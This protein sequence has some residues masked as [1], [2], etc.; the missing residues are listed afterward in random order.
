MGDLVDRV[1]ELGQTAVAVTDHGEVSGHLRFQKA[2]NGWRKQPGGQET[3]TDRQ[4]RPIYGI[5]TYMAE[6][7]FVRDGK[8]GENYDHMVLLAKDDQG[9]R[10]LWA[11]SSR[12]YIEG[13]YYANAR[14]DWELLQEYHEGLVATGACLSGVVPKY[15]NDEHPQYNPDKAA[16]RLAR[17]LEIFGED[18]YLEIHT[19]RD[20]TQV[21][22]NHALVKL[23]SDMG[24]P[25][26]AVSDAHYL[27]PDDWEDHELLTAMQMSLS[28]DD[29][30]RYQ[31]G[32]NQLCMFGESEVRERLA[33][34]GPDVV[35][36]AV[37]NTAKI[38]A[39]CDAALPGTR[40]MPVFFDTPE[41]DL[42]RTRRMAEEGFDRK[43]RQH[44]AEDKWPEY[45]QRLEYEFGII[46]SKGFPG[47]FLTVADIVKWAKAEGML[48]GP[49]RGSA[50]GS[51]LS[52]VLDIT[53]IDPIKAGL[54][55]ER[56]L[57]PGRD[58]LPDIDMDFPQLERP[59]VRKH[60]EEQYGL[61]N[62]ATIG[63][64][65]KLAPK[66]LMRDLGRGLR[67]PLQEIN[68][69]NKIVD[70]FPDL[71]VAH[72]ETPW[73]AIEAELGDQLR[74]YLDK[75]PRLFTLMGK[76]GD[77]I[78]HAGAHAA[79]VV[80]SKDSLLGRLPLRFKSDDI[81]TQVDFNDVEEL[82]F[83]KIDVLGLR[84]LSTLM[85]AYKLVQQFHPDAD[86]PF[87]HDWQYDWDKFYEDPEVH[88]SLWAGKNIGVFQLESA[89]LRQ[90]AKRFQ[91]KSL[92]DICAMISVYRPGITRTY[93]EETGLNL[94]EL[95][96]QKRGGERQATYKHELLRPILEPTHGNFLYQEQ[97]MQVCHVLAGYS[98]AETD[99]VRKILGKKLVE[100]MK[101]ERQIFV[102]GCKL[103]D[104]AETVAN[105]I[106]D[107]MVAFGLYG[108]NRCL[109][110]KSLVYRPN[111]NGSQ[112]AAATIESLY[113][114][115]HFEQFLLPPSREH[116]PGPCVVC[117]Q[118]ATRCIPG[119]KRSGLLYLR[120][121]CANCISWHQV[122]KR[123]GL[124]L[125]AEKDG[126]IVPDRLKDV[127]FQG[128]QPV[129]RIT[130]ANGMF[131]EATAN[132]RSL[133][134]DG[135]RRTDEL[136]PGDEMIVH[137]E[138][139]PT[140]W[141]QPRYRVN[142]PGRSGG[143][144][145][146]QRWTATAVLDKRCS[147]CGT[148]K[149]RIERSHTDGHR[150][151]NAPEN[152]AW[153][154]RGCHQKR[155]RLHHGRRRFWEKGHTTAASVVVSVDYVGVFPTY[156]IEMAGENHNFV[157]NG[158]VTH[159][160]HGYA[161]AMIAY[162]CAWMKHFFPR[163]FMTALFQTNEEDSPLYA[164]ECQR[165]GIP[166]RGPDINES[167]EDFTLTPGGV[168]R[169]GLAKIKYVASGSKYL[170][171]FRP[172]TGVAD[173]TKRMPKD[174]FNKRAATS[175][176]IVGA[177]DSLVQP[178]DED[179]FPGWPKAQIALRLYLENRKDKVAREL[180]NVCRE[181]ECAA[182]AE[183]SN[184]DHLCAGLHVADRGFCEKEYL[185]SHISHDPLAPYMQLLSSEESFPGEDNMLPGEVCRLGGII[186]RV[187][188]LVTKKGKNPGSEMCQFWVDLPVVVADESPDGS[189][190]DE[191]VQ[192]V[193]FPEA[194]QK[195][196]AII[197]PGAPVL[198][199]VRRMDEGLSLVRLFRLDQL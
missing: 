4:C 9:L 196:K 117:G 57:D 141:R 40:S 169:Y 26:I 30:K 110:G 20:P 76:F 198:C 59:L 119:K 151:N 43:I 71:E 114:R 123:R 179:R 187:R 194:W 165:L 170:A 70:T 10:N 140:D 105:S 75:Y 120:G 52:Y 186:N 11:L 39:Q 87:Y 51:L 21:K 184:F 95:Y 29:P 90:L 149:G 135:Y 162:W 53:E 100:K 193:T 86:I 13:S 35:E 22:V 157:A 67:V 79:G 61:L 96:L 133:T 107:D 54:I 32:P 63:T 131:L 134:A 132:H 177:L 48:A 15:L 64:L 7:R 142:A 74:P 183:H 174:K 66:T 80:L 55:F 17:L 115:I 104:I 89:G 45:E 154:C 192:I 47:Y 93:D 28:Y 153:R 73:S 23:A 121:R 37:S 49:G 69:I 91:P 163:E 16:A 160:S 156:D 101:L 118:E 124:R 108:F 189:R 152:L 112:P 168:I 136:R 92:E 34:L 83:V 97:I 199:D 148:D 27:R 172:F 50:S 38:A 65:N 77:H 144:T 190:G 143:W 138:Y 18:F 84:T 98:L 197:E 159:N 191:Q 173:F 78:R 178:E 125:L 130:L 185:G 106:F 25:L 167:E 195:H 128:E 158:I 41:T 36:E 181:A 5:E 188:P 46:A 62:V 88:R 161:Y 113:R 8:K 146:F 68:A 3:Q 14:C 44:V 58:S 99:R 19:F 60:L 109:G 137:G 81:R 111:G 145:A 24:V 2:A 150:T 166:L 155:D 82:G 56:F 42:L 182:G 102:D 126:R 33:Y 72:V 147:E 171:E 127:F 12:A 176:I 85:R 129:W 103:N 116:H 139:E 6:D 31:Y 122:W 94:L 175:A 180:G 1:V 164:R